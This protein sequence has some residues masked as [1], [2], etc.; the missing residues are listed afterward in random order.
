M[1]SLAACYRVEVI[2]AAHG[3]ARGARLCDRHTWIRHRKFLEIPGT[4]DGPEA[5]LVGH[6]RDLESF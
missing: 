6:L 3:Y 2:H 5:P 1:L 4:V